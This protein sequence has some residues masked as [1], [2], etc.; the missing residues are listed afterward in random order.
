MTD[1]TILPPDPLRVL[2][3]EDNPSD[4]QL[5]ASVLERGGFSVQFDVA[6]SSDTFR[7]R[8]EKGEYDLI[9]ADLE[10]SNWTALDALEILKGS[11][12][13]IPLIVV[14]G[15]LGERAAVE[16]IKRGAADFVFKDRPERLPA[17]VQ[18][19][20]ED[21]RL[22]TEN[23]R[24]FRANSELAMIGESSD[25]AIIGKTLDGVITSWNKGAEELYGYAAAEALGRPISILVSP[26]RSEEL[27]QILAR[28]R[29]GERIEH[30]ES[31]R[32]RKDGSLVDVSL[33]MFPLTGPG[34]EVIGAATIAR[35][36]TQRKRAEAELLR[37][38]R[39]LRTI[40]ACNQVLVRATEESHL[41]EDV[42]GILVREGGYRM[43]W[44]G[45]AEQDEGKSVRPVAHAG[46]EEGYLQ[47]ANITWA[48]TERGHGPTGTAI[49]T[50]K[51]MIARNIQTEPSLA[52][53][54]AD[55]LK[56]GYASSVALP[57]LLNVRVLGALSIYAEEPD[58]FASGEM[59]LLKEL[60]S[61]LGFGIQA[62]RTIAEHRRAEEA[63]DEE[64][65]LLYTLMDNLPDL[66]YFK[67]RESHFTRINLALAKKFDLVHPAQA[68]GKTDFDFL[69]AEHAEAF[70]KDDGQLLETG[71]PIV[72]KEEKGVWPDGQVSW[73]STT[74]MPLRDANGNIVGT[75]GVSRDITEHRKAEEALRESEERFRATFENA[76]IGMA[77][78]DLQGHPL[79]SNPA[80]QQMLGYNEEELS[81][82]VFT[83]YTYTDDQDLDWRLFSELVAGKRE[84]YETEKRF[85]K[86]GGD[87]VW[88]Q[89]TASLVKDRYGRPVCVVGMV[90]DITG[91]RRA[92][93]ALNEERH[94]FCTLMDNLP[95]SIYFKD[96]EGRFTQI[97]LAVS[98]YLGL[99]HPALAAGK[100]DFDFFSAELAREFRKDEERII[101][102]GQPMVGKEEKV[103]W[104]GGKVAWASTTKMPLRDAQGNIVGTFGVSRDITERKQAEEALR[105]SEARL[106]EA[107]HVAHVGSSSW[108]VAT[109][110]TTW[111]DE[112]Y[113]I[114]GRDPR[115]PP[116]SHK[117]RAA[118][119]APESWPRLENAV[120]RALATG[121]PYDLDLEVVRSDG[122]HFPAHARGA[123]VRGGDGRIVRLYGTLQDITE[124]KQAEEALRQSEAALKEALLAAQMGV[125]EWTAETDTVI[126]DENLYH[127]AGRDPKLPAP[128]YKQHQQFFAPESWE[129]LKAAAEN[130]LAT[131][132]SYQ[133]D[134]ELLC[135]DGSKRWLIGRGE[136]LRDASGRIT[137]IR[138]TV[139]DITERKKAEEALQASEARF[140]S[141]IERAPVAISLTRSGLRLF[142]NQKFLDMFGFQSV[143]DVVGH[144]VGG[145]WSPESR[146]MIEERARQRSLGLPV[147]ARY[148]AVGQR[149][150]GSQFPSEIAVVMV[151]LPDGP[152]SVGFLT[153]ITDRKRAEDALR[154]SEER[155]RLFMDNSP[156][157][158]W[159]K[160]EKGHYVYISETFQKRFG[161]R[162]E[163]YVG[164]T[165]FEI[166]P[167]A[168]AEEFRKN[169]RAALAAGHA[170]EIIEKSFGRDGELRGWLNYK[171]P[172]QDASGQVLVAGIGLDIT[173]RKR[174]E[175]ALLES[176]ERFRSL[177][178]NATVGIYRTTPQ[179][180]ILMANPTLV[181][182]LGFKD[183]E[184][185]ATR[186]LEEDGFEPN[187][188]RKLFR[189]RMEKDGVV[190]G[191]EEAWTRQDGSAIFVRE[192]A[193]AIRGEDGK[194]M[195]YDGIVEDITEHKRAEEAL[196]LTQFSVEHASD[197]VFW[198]DPQG[199]IL[200]V[201]EAA[202]R[203]L[204]RSHEELLSLSI[205]EIDPLVRKNGWGKSWAAV[206]ARG[207]AVLETQH[208]TKQGRVFPVEVTANY[209]EFG[210]K[211]YSFSFARDITER[212]QAEAEH[213]R[214]VTAIEQSAEAVVITSTSGEIEYVNP[215]FSRITGY[216]REE[217]LGQNPRMLKSGNQDPAL[218][219]QLWE[220]IL[221]GKVWHGELI[222]RRK[223][224]S[225]YHEQMN[226]AP[227]RG[228]G[229]EVTHFIA[230]KQD[231]TA[232]KE[233]EQRFV[234]AQKMEAVGRLAGGVAHDFNNLLT[235][236]NGYAQI[237]TQRSSPKDPRRSLFEEI[238]MAGERAATLTRQLLAFSRRQVLEPRVLDLSS[239]LGNTEK[240]LRR[241]IGEDI[242]LATKLNPGLGRVK[243]DPGQIEQVIMNLAVNARDAMPQGGK[244]II[245]TANVEVDEDFARS[246]KP[247]TTGKYVM[248]SVSDTGCGMDLATQAHMF[249]PFFTTKPKGKGTGLGLATVYGIIKQSGGFIW[250]YSEPGQ[251][252]TFKI[253]F[254]CVQEVAPTAAHAKV[255]RAT[256]LAKGKET[257][258]VV[259][260]EVGVRSLVCETLK[261]KGYN[262]LE[263]EGGAQALNIAER[264][265]KPIH[266]LLTDV[267]MPLVGGKELA[268]RLSASHPESKVLYMSGY[269][270][271]AVVRHGIADGGPPLLQKPFLPNALL[272]KVREVLRTKR[273]IRK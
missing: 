156:T 135:T 59:Q 16:C 232:R 18:R 32:V 187:Y 250:V 181:R 164:K 160:D 195:Y 104:P 193:R 34:G 116:P 196:R 28:L 9:L 52:P 89:L 86:K 81:R 213:V 165:D 8:L 45:Y 103:T 257:I 19:V 178:E 133:L 35:D 245:E 95:D 230:T 243:V 37:V 117:E 211:E 69:P 77:L 56:R 269:T 121:E 198:M 54:Q 63:L 73:V 254:P 218:Y 25:D 255:R 119:Y 220:T 2:I 173:D 143:E 60:S 175:A 268:T 33:S 120:Q 273:G 5:M 192:S 7:Q 241:L 179:G 113:R 96:R 12:R 134:L 47:T 85:L 87:V 208:Q 182:M 153:D 256:K 114:T 252:A 70:H 136:P 107:E 40:S 194:I 188:A 129:R 158:A 72:G 206:K 201:N 27:P 55:Q 100:T 172:L 237:L 146:P 142:V 97:N 4:A 214:L 264:Y 62:L 147:P 125:W 244:F 207:S 1:R 246:H 215:A 110:T 209:L 262:T 84:K 236:I 234:Q 222:N 212:K 137:Q 186:N 203:S 228:E 184:E 145:Q 247:M 11:A 61:D 240:L 64:R 233:L 185:L 166:F 167:H 189:E 38:N 79:K 90:Q 102:T 227:V 163:D 205:P 231:I 140:R 242:E 152:A 197:A 128:T 30:Y 50:G 238:Q 170:I 149:K 272:L 216:S 219:Q 39:A 267:V 225:L 124:R 46:C 31:V 200:Y 6:D 177:V 217:A 74:K 162:P 260:D 157:V 93:A 101:G 29:R 115:Q 58:A 94:L 161:V 226:I 67:D 80:L 21:H 131:G 105:E 66:I 263:A 259:E 130:S 258:L 106:K 65:H 180:D 141:L 176:E 123:A 248:V 151:D 251:G 126:W 159:M 71:L 154:K 51:T 169:D 204:G 36:I 174:A 261:S 41:L 168:M 10:L 13:E 210:G 83:E 183:F 75:F 98:K 171:F 224:G 229:G 155:F 109:D 24:A 235:V 118:L 253:Y 111:S 91:R 265:T 44:V 122:T 3:A 26:D 49:R 271:D 199:R 148:E 82:M 53:W 127:I 22:H 76:A 239:V 48:D 270:D 14:T 42:C 223:D 249:E 191:M 138:G 92:E 23:Q 144:P 99:D 139:Q 15:A 190:T 221:Q 150:D 17:A 68:V 78:V 112:L 20:L 43:A 57:I 88:G 132:S 108:D 202:C 266:L